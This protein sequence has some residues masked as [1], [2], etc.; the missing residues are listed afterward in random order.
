MLDKQTY[1]ELQAKLEDMKTVKRV[2]IREAIALALEHGDLKEN[3]AYHT[4]KQE[5]GLNEMRI[6]DLEARLQDEEI[7]DENS[8]PK[9]SVVPGAIVT[10]R[11]L[12]TKKEEDHFVVYQLGEDLSKNFITAGSPLGKQIMGAV[13]GDVITFTNSYGT[14]TFEVLKIS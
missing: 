1:D 3:S 6:R 9:D 13:V 11:N 4:A 10:L 14:T 8:G 12:A 7:A 2:K 5:Q